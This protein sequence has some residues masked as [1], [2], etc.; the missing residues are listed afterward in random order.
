MPVTSADNLTAIPFPVE[1]VPLTGLGSPPDL[2]DPVSEE[3]PMTAEAETTETPG[4]VSEPISEATMTELPGVTSFETL[5]PP[6]T[7]PGPEPH[8]MEPPIT[9]D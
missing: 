6:K 3:I 8:T 4:T 5:P 1:D 2:I 9:N 7:N